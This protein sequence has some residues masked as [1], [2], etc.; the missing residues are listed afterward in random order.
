MRTYYQPSNQMP[1]GG[2]GGFMAGGTVVAVALAF[3]YAFVTWYVPFTSFFAFL[4]FGGLFGAAL[5]ALVRRGKLRNPAAV[6]QL[7]LL[8]GLV[9]TYT[10]WSVYLTLRAGAVP[11][12]AHSLLLRANGRFDPGTWAGLAASPRRMMEAMHGITS[13]SIDDQPLA[14]SWWLLL[15]WVAETLV[16]VGMASSW[17]HAQAGKPFSEAA[18]AWATP[19]I[20]PWPAAHVQDLAALKL[21]LEAGDYRAIESRAT[22][23]TVQQLMAWPGSFTRL[24]FYSVPDDP[25]CRYLKLESFVGE[26]RKGTTAFDIKTVVAY[27]HLSPAAYEELRQRFAMPATEAAAPLDSAEA[28]IRDTGR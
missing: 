8:A 26:T 15:F 10:Q 23:S 14:S 4:A 16:I 17:A 25:G 20:M 6:F 13:W 2:G 3:G 12:Q 18:N 28:E 19:E 1:P 11:A 5:A 27:L 9:A 7:A 24:T 21:A 22:K